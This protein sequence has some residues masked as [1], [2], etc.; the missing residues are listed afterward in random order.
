MSYKYLGSVREQVQR[1]E[2]RGRG[3]GWVQK[4]GRVGR[5]KPRAAGTFARGIIYTSAAFRTLSQKAIDFEETP[6]SKPDK[7]LPEISIARLTLAKCKVAEVNKIYGTCDTCSKTT[8][9]VHN[10]SCNCSGCIPDVVPPFQRPSRRSKINTDIAPAEHLSKIQRAHG[11]TR[12]I[13]LCCK[14]GES[15]ANRSNGMIWC[16]GV[17]HGKVGESTAIWTIFHLLDGLGLLHWL[18]PTPSNAR[19]MQWDSQSRR[20]HLWLI[21]F[22]N[23]HSEAVND[24]VQHFLGSKNRP[25]QLNSMTTEPG[26]Y[27]KDMCIFLGCL[28]MQ[29][30]ALQELPPSATLQQFVF[31]GEGSACDSAKPNLGDPNVEPPLDERVNL[32]LHTANVNFGPCLC[33]AVLVHNPQLKMLEEPGTRPIGQHVEYGCEEFS[34]T[35][36]R[37]LQRFQG[38]HHVCSLQNPVYAF[39]VGQGRPNREAS[40]SR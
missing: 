3:R 24:E 30:V 20:S 10:P 15:L 19:G 6:T 21:M 33:R 5:T 8:S 26:D 35:G 14:G 37:D 18:K 22:R 31:R 39:G 2:W 34:G 23:L 11:F 27:S 7:P 13:G 38:R 9:S 29:V 40:E 36:L 17:K 1:G 28:D 25:D 12:P 32:Q 16:G 4:L